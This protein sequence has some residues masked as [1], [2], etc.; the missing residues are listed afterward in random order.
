MISSTVTD[1]PLILFATKVC[2]V[3]SNS[4][5]SLVASKLKISFSISRDTLARMSFVSLLLTAVR[6]QFD[7]VFVSLFDFSKHV[8]RLYG[9]DG[10]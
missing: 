9:D 1:V 7:N 10:Y 6:S 4:N 5:E 3:R 8:K 2:K